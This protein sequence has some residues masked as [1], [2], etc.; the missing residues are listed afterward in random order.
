[1]CQGN[2]FYAIDI[3]EASASPV[4]DLR[5]DKGNLKI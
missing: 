2:L 5:K 4:V 1:M 3:G